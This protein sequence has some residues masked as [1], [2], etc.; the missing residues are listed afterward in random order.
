MSFIADLEVNPNDFNSGLDR[1]RA[2]MDSFAESI[3]AST[4]K[5]GGAL[6]DVG[7]VLSVGVIG[8]MTAA[9]GTALMLGTR[10]GGLA[11]RLLDLSDITGSSTDLIQQ[12]Q[13]VANQAGVS[14]EA[15]TNATEGLVRKLS[16][17]D[18]ESSSVNN[19]FKALGVSVKDTS[20]NMRNGGEMMDEVI[21]KLAGVTDVM[22]RNS[23]GSQ[24]FGGAWKDMAPILGMGAEGI[25]QVKK[26]ASDLGLVLSNESLQGANKFRQ[27]MDQI[28]ARVDGLKDDLGIK[29]AAVMQDTF[30]P[31]VTNTLIPLGKQVV[32]FIG[33]MADG[34]N[35]LSDPAKKLVI[36]FA[37]I[38]AASG[39]FLIALGTAVKL[40]PTLITGFSAL[41]GPVGIAV[42]VISGAA[43]LIYKNWDKIREYFTTGPAAKMWDSL[44]D[45]AKR[46]W[47]VLTDV[48]T[49]LSSFV[50]SIW[51]RI[52]SNIISSVSSAFNIVMDVVGVAMG[53]ITGTLNVFSALLNGDFSGALRAVGNMFRSVFNSMVDIA[54]N[55]IASISN[56]LAGLLKLIGAD[57]LGRGLEDFATKITPVKTETKSLAVATEE[58]AKASEDQSKAI[59]LVIPA[60]DSAKEKTRNYREELNAALASMNIYEGRLAV[61]ATEYANITDVAK[62]AGASQE[63]FRVLSDANWVDNAI[64]RLD[65]LGNT[66]EALKLKTLTNTDLTKVNLDFIPVLRSDVF[67][68]VISSY[69]KA[70]IA[71]AQS[72][73]NSIREVFEGGFQDLFINIAEGI[74]GALGG[75]ENILKA[76]GSALLSTMGGVMVSLGTMAI[77]SGIAIEAVKT[78]LTTLQGPVAIAAGVA[79]VAIGSAFRAGA[80][81]LGSSGGGGGYSGASG[82]TSTYAAP[83]RQEGAYGQN[84]MN[85]NITGSIEADGN[86]LKV[87]LD[88]VDNKNKRAGGAV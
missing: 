27:S 26:Q 40:I 1:A 65:K 30:V 46:V 50:S 6:Q 88:N 61:I 38:A 85:I 78:A 71:A 49:K 60:L 18:K 54:A 63:E 8:S 53:F 37:G 79:L 36:S 58:A 42:A 66:Y 20:G 57:G 81:K 41:T 13:Y 43:V 25:E 31:F 15:F 14:S 29:L 47:A 68:N 2:K 35:N 82:S 48:F 12:Y 70:G 74:G 77:K 52:G 55:A 28:T 33:R 69:G 83:V 24:L 32:D 4:D 64:V 67:Q 87:L 45:A 84:Q 86:K 51:D 23:V 3:K 73:E 39:P 44:T 34:F 7:A 10:V 9:A 22:K 5:I 76:A 59:G 56:Q 21:I 17:V 16:Q 11:D 72:F 62:K 80:G 75:G 19:I